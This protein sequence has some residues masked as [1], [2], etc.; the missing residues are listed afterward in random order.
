MKFTMLVD[1][2]FVIIT[3]LSVC[4]T[5]PGVA[6]KILK[7]IMHFHRMTFIAMPQD[8]NPCPGGHEIYNVGYHSMHLVCLNHVQD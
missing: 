8:K 4:L 2:S 6:K 7:E 5:W 1:S 3:L